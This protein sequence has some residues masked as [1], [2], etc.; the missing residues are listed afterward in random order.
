MIVTEFF[1][2]EIYADENGHIDPS[3]QKVL[4]YVN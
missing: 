2:K 3:N 4:R 1:Q